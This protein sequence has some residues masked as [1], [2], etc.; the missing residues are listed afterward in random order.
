M[1]NIY[2]F[3]E[4]FESIPDYKKI[5]SLMFLKK[6]DVNFLYE[7]G[8]LKGDIKFLYKEFKQI[9]LEL[10]EEYLDHIKIQE[11]AIIEKILNK[12]M[13]QYFNTIFEDIRHERSL[14]LLLPLTDPDI[15]KQSKITDD[16]LN[17]IKSLALEKVHRQ[18]IF[19]EYHGVSL[20]K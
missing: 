18:R 1:D 20:L 7:C 5:V 4:L 17:K 10:N 2:Y 14:I 8:F 3:K 16:E 6:N 9:L 13:E 12:E 19:K 11:E 15:L